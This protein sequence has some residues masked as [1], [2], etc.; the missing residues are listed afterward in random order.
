MARS[1]LRIPGT[2]ARD[3]G[4]K[5]VLGK[6]KPGMV[7]EGE[8]AA[9][10]H[11]KVSRSAYREAVRIL[12]AKGLV[13]SRPKM[14]T[15]VSDRAHWHLL[16]PD[17]LSWIFGSE[18]PE[19]LVA[20]LFELRRIVEPQAAALAARRRSKAQL[21]LM[22]AALSQMQAYTL[23]TEEGRLADQ[24]FHATLLAASGNDFLVSLTSG[25]GA[26]V[27]WTTVFK[28]RRQSLRRDPMPDHYKV[29]RAVAARD[30][31]GAHAAMMALLDLAFNDTANAR[32]RN[33]KN[34]R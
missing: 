3:L 25:I 19:A 12:A 13:D 21:D 26:A 29:W 11:R 23:K 17:V 20:A 16:D 9:S 32:W 31:A 18:P 2:I 28:Q 34:V 4:A 6:Y 15:R 22:E 8:V 14:G 33:K 27:A 10:E 7:L 5:I 30:A 1:P 24:Q